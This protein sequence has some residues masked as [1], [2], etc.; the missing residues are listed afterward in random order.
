[1]SAAPRRTLAGPLLR[2]VTCGRHLPEDLRAAIKPDRRT[3]AIR[4]R[5]ELLAHCK[6]AP[7]TTERALVDLAE[8][9]KI[10][11][12]VMDRKLRTLLAS[13]SCGAGAAEVLRERDGVRHESPL[14]P[15]PEQA[16]E[17][18]LCFV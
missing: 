13:A 9:L 2:P 7:S 6:G 18:G 17:P 3:E 16:T 11:L 10:R 5:R 12:L 1:M 4:F 14:M 15:E 8:Q